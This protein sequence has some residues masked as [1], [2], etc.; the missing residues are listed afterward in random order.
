MAGHAGLAR[1][2]ADGAR[3]S[4]AARLVGDRLGRVLIKHLAA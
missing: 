1:H 4:R 3:R 2:R